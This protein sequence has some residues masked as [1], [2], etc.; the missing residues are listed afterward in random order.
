MERFF[1]SFCLF[2]FAE[3]VEGQTVDLKG[4]E[5]S[6]IRLHDVKFTTDQ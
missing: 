2:S 6:E 3:E 4:G 5:M 1:F